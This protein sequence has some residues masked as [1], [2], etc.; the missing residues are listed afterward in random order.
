[1]SIFSE[2]VLYTKP[3]IEVTLQPT[4]SCLLLMQC[5]A[6]TPHS[7]T[8]S[9]TRAHTHTLSLSLDSLCVVCSP[10]CFCALQHLLEMIH[11]GNKSVGGLKRRM[12]GY[13]ILGFI[14]YGIDLWSSLV[15][16]S[17]SSSLRVRRTV[18]VFTST[19]HARTC[20]FTAGYYMILVTK[21]TQLACLGGHP[22]YG[23][24]DTGRKDK[25]V[26]CDSLFNQECR[27]AHLHDSLCVAYIYI[28]APGVVPSKDSGVETK[29]KSLFFGVDLT[30][31][32]FSYSYDLTHT[33]QHNMTGMC[34]GCAP[35]CPP[36]L[37]CSCLF[38]DVQCLRTRTLVNSHL[39]SR[40]ILF[41]CLFVFC[42]VL[43]RSSSSFF[44]FVLLLLL[45][46]II[47][48]LRS[49][50][51]FFF[52]VLLL[53]LCVIILLL[54]SSSSLCTS[55]SFFSCATCSSTAQVHDGL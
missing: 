40:F 14:R 1:L 31:F 50:S 9:L 15:S 29:Y 44:F 21:R 17:S 26:F 43:L 11:S 19:L 24:A 39:S 38:G 2:S 23:V 28:P 7:L 41:V 25:C 16:L 55:S 4:D 35:V 27:S 53:L 42:L 52:F 20:S 51:S 18:C 30:N 22:I 47:L 13:A 37:F 10:T 48:L 36:V 8:H 49:S 33:L 34:V 45:C 54:R 32:Y 5:H 12:T 46:V 6:L 3:E